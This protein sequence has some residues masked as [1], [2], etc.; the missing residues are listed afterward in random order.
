MGVPVWILWRE[1]WLSGRLKDSFNCAV[2]IL[3]IGVAW[4]IIAIA[5]ALLDKEPVGKV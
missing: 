3:D 5:I 1:S 2:Y 4:L